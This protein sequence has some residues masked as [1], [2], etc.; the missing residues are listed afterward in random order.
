MSEDPKATVEIKRDEN[1]VLQAIFIQTTAMRNTYSQFGSLIHIDSTFSLNLEN[2]QAY[3]CVVENNNLN[4]RPVAYCFLQSAVLP[5]LEFFYSSMES[6]NDLSK[7]EIIIVDK[8]LTNI[9]LIKNYFN[10][11]KLR[12]LLCTFHSL[13]Y[14]RQNV[15]PKVE[16]E[17]DI[18]HSLN[19]KFR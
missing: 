18:K 12:I 14:I 10:N 17:M 1:D 6:Y 5:N 19:E 11:E 4:A 8:D 9:D 15:L 16:T 13:K 2:F 3:I 7:T